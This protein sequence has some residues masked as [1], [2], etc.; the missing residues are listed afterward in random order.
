M[1]TNLKRFTISVTPDMKEELTD[2]KQEKYYNTTQNEMIRE[3]I[4]KGLIALK[5]EEKEAQQEKTA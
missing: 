1:A 3:L 5:T 4:K 2:L